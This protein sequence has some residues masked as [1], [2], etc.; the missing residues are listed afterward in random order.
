MKRAYDF[1]NN[2][3]SFEAKS[4]HSSKRSCD[5]S[6]IMSYNINN[7]SFYMDTEKLREELI[8]WKIQY[9]KKSQDYYEL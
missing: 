9:N 1:L 8:Q 7:N 5:S 4:F 6:S 3:S 2:Q